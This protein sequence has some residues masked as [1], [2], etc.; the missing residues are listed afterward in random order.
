VEWALLEVVTVIDLVFL[1]IE[2]DLQ[3]KLVNNGDF[4]VS[5]KFESALIVFESS[6]LSL[7]LF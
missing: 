7:A 3:T 5:I 4:A 6:S 1:R 2:S